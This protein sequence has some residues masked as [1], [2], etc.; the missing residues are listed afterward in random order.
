MIFPLDPV[1]AL[2]Q[3]P[4]FAVVRV[5]GLLMLGCFQDRSLSQLLFIPAH[6]EHFAKHAQ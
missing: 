4:L 3:V 1:T 2:L 6:V 5:W